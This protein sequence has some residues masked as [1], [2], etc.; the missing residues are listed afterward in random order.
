MQ[1]ENGLNVLVSVILGIA[2]LIGFSSMLTTILADLELELKVF[3][4]IPVIYLLFVLLVIN[5]WNQITQDD[6]GRSA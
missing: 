1:I 4:A 2:I 3:I 5:P 6:T